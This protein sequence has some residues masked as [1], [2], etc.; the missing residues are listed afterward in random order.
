MAFLNALNLIMILSFILHSKS[1]LDSVFLRKYFIHS[2]P[3]AILHP[4]LR[5]V[6]HTVAWVVTS[7]FQL[8]PSY[9]LCDFVHEQGSGHVFDVVFAVCFCV[10]TIVHWS[11]Q[12]TVTQTAVL[13]S[14]W[15]ARLIV[16]TYSWV[17][18]APEE[19]R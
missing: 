12:F 3:V 11:M 19:L 4:T 10:M 15:D 1:A 17:T 5:Y 7:S 18:L 8:S 14:C 2:F 9:L 16:V 13:C 6:D